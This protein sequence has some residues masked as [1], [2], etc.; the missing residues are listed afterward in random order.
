MVPTESDLERFWA[1]VE[2]S[3]G[4]WLWTSQLRNGYGLFG[5]NGGTVSAH[6]FSYSLANELER[7][8]KVCHSCDTP[9]CVR[10]SHLFKG[11]HKMN[12]DDMRSKGRGHQGLTNEQIMD[13]R[14]R[15]LTGTVCRDLAAEF[16]VSS[17]QIKNILNGKQYAWLPGAR[18]VPQ[19]F[20]GLSLTPE[21]VE[22]IWECAKNPKWGW[23]SALAR[24]FGVGRA[25][26]NHV[27]KGR[28]RYGSTDTA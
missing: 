16:G 7:G 15:E 12:M 19:Q 23:Q 20:T 10:P 17:N 11:T 9:A 6:R 24:K 8:E 3:D 25:T 27:V 18:E 2:K 5:F 4:C 28:L 21:Q 13:I 1:K 14:S 26:I 22:E